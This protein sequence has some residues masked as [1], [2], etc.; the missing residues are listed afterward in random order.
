MTIIYKILYNLDICRYEIKY[1]L[2]H[3]IRG[4]SISQAYINFNFFNLVALGKI[5]KI[6]SSHYNT[7]SNVKLYDRN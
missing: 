1:Q 6:N 2:L 4:V 5:H 7:C 3:N